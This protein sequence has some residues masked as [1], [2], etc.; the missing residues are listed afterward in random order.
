MKAQGHAGSC[1]QTP[2]AEGDRSARERLYLF[3]IHPPAHFF[4]LLLLS[5]SFSRIST[6]CDVS[7]S[8][9]VSLITASNLF[10]CTVHHPAPHLSICAH[11][12]CTGTS[13]TSEQH[14]ITHMYS[15]E[16]FIYSLFPSDINWQMKYKVAAIN[17]EL[18][19]LSL[20]AFTVSVR[21]HRSHQRRLWR[22]SGTN[23][24][25]VCVETQ[26][27]VHQAVNV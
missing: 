26:H 20:T 7:L 25:C 2:S 16:S 13:A 6:F 17:S 4:P 9:H 21:S 15:Q 5:I 11:S 18:L 8:S 14:V 23:S 1:R 12:H 27:C 3:L 22:Q 10:C 19:L 24:S